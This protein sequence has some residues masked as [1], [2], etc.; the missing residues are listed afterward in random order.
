MG[1]WARRAKEAARGDESLLEKEMVW[2]GEIGCR[3]RLSEDIDRGVLISP[4]VDYLRDTERKGQFNLNRLQIDWLQEVGRNPDDDG[5]ML[6]MLILGTCK[7]EQ[8]DHG[9]WSHVPTR[10]GR[11]CLCQP[12][13]GC[14]KTFRM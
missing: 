4:S 6:V 8:Q 9:Q 13:S 7:L 1:D 14:S 5:G 12:C 2:K 3:G 10:G 11:K